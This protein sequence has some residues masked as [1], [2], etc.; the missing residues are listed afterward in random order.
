MTD[1]ATTVTTV[2][3]GDGRLTSKGD[4][5]GG[6]GASRTDTVRPNDGRVT[7]AAPT[8]PADA[9]AA[10]RDEWIK[11]DLCNNAPQMHHRLLE[12]VV[13]SI[14]LNSDL[15]KMKLDSGLPCF[16]RYSCSV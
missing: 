1:G 11:I 14:L 6:K 10:I 8:N 5:N 7:S 12:A 3:A 9:Y 4:T 13:D 16:G 15:T 2:E